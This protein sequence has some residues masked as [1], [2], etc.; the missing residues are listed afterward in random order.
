MKNLK[1]ICLFILILLMLA[2]LI[3]YYKNP[4]VSVIISS[5]NMGDSLENT[6]QSIEKQTYKNWELI[7]IDDGSVDQTS[8]ILKKYKENKKIK[9]IKNEHNLGLIKSLNKGLEIA[10][11]K[12][13]AR[14]D[15]DDVSYPNRLQRQVR[16]MEKEK[17]DLLGSYFSAGGREHILIDNSNNS[18]KLGLILLKKNIIAHPTVMIRKSFLKKH[19]LIYDE[20]YIYAEDYNLWTQIFIRGGKLGYLGGEPV[21]IYH[22]TPHSDEWIKIQKIN[23]QKIRTNILSQIIPDFNEEISE[24]PLCEFISEIIKGNRHTNFFNQEHLNKAYI[25]LC[26]Q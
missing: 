1:I 24:L 25:E 17:T 20:N 12:Y 26:K 4:K 6:I 13:I 18:C 19:N 23:T 10:K 9:I 16:F 11:G 8:E 7:V 5:Y 3:S 15:A 14:L 22:Y 2:G 21:T